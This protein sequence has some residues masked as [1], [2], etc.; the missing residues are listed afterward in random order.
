MP[1]ERTLVIA[2]LEEKGNFKIA[3]KLRDLGFRAIAQKYDSINLDLTC[4][5]EIDSTFL[6][7]MAMISM[8]MTK[9]MHKKLGVQNYQEH[10]RKEIAGLGL[11]RILEL[12]PPLEGT[13]ESVVLE[14]E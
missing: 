4:C 3:A 7:V 14:K 6:G 11:T 5:E 2:L 13:I 12:N 10:I 8:E 1:N 9:T